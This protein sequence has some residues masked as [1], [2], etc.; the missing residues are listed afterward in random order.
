MGVAEL[1]PP[2]GVHLCGPRMWAQG[3]SF[4]FHLDCGADGGN[5]AAV[6]FASYGNAQGVCG[7]YTVGQQML[8][9]G[10]R[11][12]HASVH[13]SFCV[14]AQPGSC[15]DASSAELVI[16]ACVGKQSCTLGPSLFTHSTCPSASAQYLAV[17][18]SP[19]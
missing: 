6:E 11:K 12:K 5:I 9:L 8:Q 7:A 10:C 15:G 1:D 3:Q 16:A 19:R 14:C 17:Q 4:D 2:S 13:S 18:V